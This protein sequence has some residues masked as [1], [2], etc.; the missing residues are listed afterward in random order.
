MKDRLAPMVKP[1]NFGCKRIALERGYFEI[2]NRPNVQLVDVNET[3]V[4]EVT[5]S[6]I[7]TTERDWDLDYVVCATGYD[8][9]TGGLLQMG[10]RGKE[11][12]TLKQKWECGVRTYLGM[13]TV[14]FPNC[15]FTYGPQAPTS[16]CNGPTCAELQGDWIVGVMNYMRAN[17]L[18]TVEASEESGE[19]WAAEVL[20]LANASLLPT[21]KS[22]GSVVLFFATDAS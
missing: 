12:Q 16:F 7:K 2:F 8:A 3:P 22:V 5:E 18:V 6:G 10:I 9:L 17:R 11:G 20:K 15:F 21:A 13:A 4:T 19:Q 14:G 1:H